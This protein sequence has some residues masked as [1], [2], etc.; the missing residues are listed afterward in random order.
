[1]GKK[2]NGTMAAKNINGKK[3]K[4]DRGSRVCLQTTGGQSSLWRPVRSNFLK[5]DDSDDEV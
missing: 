4:W 1:M 5:Y 3:G 2:E